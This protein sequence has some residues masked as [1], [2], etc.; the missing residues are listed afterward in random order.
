M[1]IPTQTR[2]PPGSGG[3]F[4]KPE[5]MQ[6]VIAD[7][8][9]RRRREGS[10]TNTE[11]HHE[12]HKTPA[13]QQSSMDD[14]G[15]EA[16]QAP[17]APQVPQEKE[18]ETLEASLKPEGVLE[19]LKELGVEITEEDIEYYLF[20]GAVEKTV[21]VFKVNKQ[22]TFSAKIRTLT[23]A[24][25]MV[26]EELVGDSLRITDMTREGVS[27]LRTLAVLS[28]AVVELMGR[29]TIKIWESS[30]HS[31]KE[32]AKEN[33]QVLK[34]LSPGVVNKINHLHAAL[35]TT[36]NAMLDDGN[37]PFLTNS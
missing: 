37:S 17:Q 23:S 34:A 16:P 20:K 15:W 8:N 36:F 10:E 26:V 13:P 9:S 3:S 27:S 6:R 19:K 7:E 29:P 2:I 28:M 11:E 25:Y 1:K 18:P 21:P 4:N 33:M 30:E 24:Q 31:E 12:Y 5:A 22:K 35:T 32:K 14:G